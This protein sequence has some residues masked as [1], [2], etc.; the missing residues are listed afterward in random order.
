MCVSQTCS[1]HQSLVNRKARGTVRQQDQQ[2]QAQL[3]SPMVTRSAAAA[4]S[5]PAAARGC[6]DAVP[7]CLQDA[8]QQ[9]AQR[10]GQ[11]Q[12]LALKQQQQQEAQQGGPDAM[13]WSPAKSS[14]PQWPSR[15]SHD[16]WLEPQ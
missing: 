3:G 1:Q 10:Q 14:G 2:Q 5:G 7:A 15:G 9:Q 12:P 13:M 11:W 4:V 6:A 8:Q 16:V